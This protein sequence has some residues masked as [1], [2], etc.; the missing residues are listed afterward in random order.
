MASS[1]VLMSA[2]LAF[3]ICRT[4]TFSSTGVATSIIFAIS[5]IRLMFCWVSVTRMEFV[6]SK[7]SRMPLSDLKPSKAFCASSVPMFLKGI[8]IE[9]TLIDSSSG[10][11]VFI[12][13]G[14]PS[15]RTFARGRARTNFSPYGSRWMPF[16]SRIVS[17]ASTCSA[18]VSFWPGRDWRVIVGLGAP[19]SFR[20]V[21]LTSFE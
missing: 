13:S 10:L 6:R 18:S 3:L 14:M 19:G 21:L 1:A 9:T 11:S 2:A 16:I 15:L 5:S 20:T 7:T 4:N 8:I 12:R 17:I